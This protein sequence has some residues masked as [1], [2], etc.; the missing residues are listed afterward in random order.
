MDRQLR[1]EDL[2]KYSSVKE[3]K[4][5]FIGAGKVADTLC[6]QFFMSGCRI[7]R[8]V[9]KTETNGAALASYCG[10]SWSR[11]Y[12][13]TDSED[14]IIVA[15]SDSA[16]NDVLLRMKCDKSTVVVHTAGSLGLEVFP[17]ALEHSGVFY[18][19]QTFTR[20]RN[21]KFIGLPFF[22]EASD[23]YSCNLMTALADLLGAEVHYATSPERRV[24]HLAA[25]FGC[26]F[27]NH[28]FTAG[29]KI[30]E[31][32][33]LSFDVLKP[34][35]IETVNKAFELG[36]ENSQ[37]GPA[38]RSDKETI[39]KH[40]DLLSFSPELREIYSEITDSIIRKYSKSGS[41]DQF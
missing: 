4:I 38:F 10:A 25:V 14:I 8:I 23:E 26:N 40:M 29:K 33:G 41:D 9:S 27:V 13:F 16:V 12:Y 19:L 11:E 28:M 2:H 18:P 3:Y 39:K 22:L 17:P 20:G 15:V 37:T 34:L 36:P 32:A 35:V 1:L 30:T 24:L 6:R 21:I 5:S 7:C 31:R